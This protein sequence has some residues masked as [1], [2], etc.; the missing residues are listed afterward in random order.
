MRLSIFLV[1]VMVAA[2]GKLAHAESAEQIQYRVGVDGMA[3]V[4]IFELF[5]GSLR[6]EHSP[7]TSN[8]VA[9]R[10]GHLQARFIENETKELYPLY[11]L[12][13]GYRHYWSWFYFSAEGGVIA[14]HDHRGWQP[15]P[16]AALMLGG[17][18]TAGFDLGVSL[19]AVAVIGPSL[20][21][22]LGF[23]FAAW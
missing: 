1:L 6:L 4:G 22:H 14:G 9:L 15:R 8:A 18:S 17:K 23:D 16:N 12:H 20:C 21:A 19:M 2:T 11:Y 5:G 13:V 7:S 3:G 10:V